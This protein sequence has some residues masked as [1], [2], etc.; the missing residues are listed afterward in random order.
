MAISTGGLLSIDG[1]SVT[2]SGTGSVSLQSPTAEISPPSGFN[3]TFVN[4]QLTASGGTL[5]LWPN[6]VTGLTN[7]GTLQA[8]IGTTLYFSADLSTP[9]NNTNGTI[10]AL[11]GG[12]VTPYNG[13][14]TGGELI[15]SGTGTFQTFDGAIT[16]TLNNLTAA[17]DFVVPSGISVA[18]AGAITNTGSFNVSQGAV[19]VSGDAT[20]QGA[21]T[22]TMS[23][24]CCNI[25]AGLSGAGNTLINESTIRGAGSIGSA[26]LTITNQKLINATALTNHLILKGDPLINNA[27]LEASGGSTLEIQSVVDN[28]GGTM[29]ALTGSGV[30]VNSGTMQ[31]GTL[32]TSGTGVFESTG[33]ALDGTS[34]IPT[35]AGTF[36]VNGGASLALAGTVKNTGTISLTDSSLEINS[37]ATLEGKKTM[38]FSSGSFMYGSGTLT[39]ES[40]IQGS[41]NLGDAGTNLAQDF[42]DGTLSGGKDQIAGTLEI[43]GDIR[44]NAAVLAPGLRRRFSAFRLQYVGKNLAIAGSFSSAGSVTID[45]TSGLSVGGSFSQ[46]GGTTTIDGT[47]TAPSGPILQEGAIFG[48]GKITAALSSTGSGV[49][50][51]SAICRRLLTGTNGVFNLAIGG[52]NVGT[53]YSQLDV[54]GGAGLSG[55]LNIG[56]I[57]LHSGR[58]QH[59]HDPD[60]QRCDRP[61]CHSERVKYQLRGTL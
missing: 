29:Q 34:N 11:S 27:M 12:T 14:Y 16:P 61:I 7:T 22:I 37:A 54:T 46:T 56:L 31:G 45:S 8:A 57:E 10:K 58:W 24:V 42:S 13:I 49:F 25:L 20:L 18:F 26:G 1:P 35:N 51:W 23:D 9:L 52:T 3:N 44:T 55:T 19:Y 59:V 38:T 33:G 30:L 32:K 21:G 53:Q 50:P 36:Q 48:Q 43:G 6:T 28:T 60:R 5:Q 41:G 17:A 4:Q 39:N 47:L 40:T 15:T 2:M